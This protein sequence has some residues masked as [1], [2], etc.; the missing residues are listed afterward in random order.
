MTLIELDSLVSLSDIRRGLNM[1]YLEH[2]SRHH[3]RSNHHYD[4]TMIMFDA[5]MADSGFLCWVICNMSTSRN[6]GNE[7]LSYQPPA[8]T[9]VKNKHMVYVLLFRQ[10]SQ[11]ANETIR[12]LSETLEPQRYTSTILQLTSLLKLQDDPQA[13]FRFFALWDQTCDEIHKIRRFIPRKDQMS[14]SQKIELLCETYE[15]LELE[16]SIHPLDSYCEGVIHASCVFSTSPLCFCVANRHSLCLINNDEKIVV[17]DGDII[18]AETLTYVPE[19]SGLDDHTSLETK[20]DGNN[21]K[22][23]MIMMLDVDHTIKDH[24]GLFVQWLVVNVHGTKPSTGDELL[25][26]MFQKNDEIRLKRH[27]L[28]IYRQNHQLN[29]EQID[30]IRLELQQNRQEFQLR[31][32]LKKWPYFKTT[33]PEA[34]NI[35][36]SNNGADSDLESISEKSKTW[37]AKLPVGG[38]EETRGNSLE[39]QP[40]RP[41]SENLTTHNENLTTENKFVKIFLR[42]GAFS[43]PS[44]LPFIIE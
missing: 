31:S 10:M 2:R 3:R 24:D 23:Y 18:P 44:C 22:Y 28:M 8:P 43:P 15:K 36:L 38:Y 34:M 9:F 39:L 30:L 4:Y 21:I 13:I 12:D 20:E 35:Y 14:P 6:M 11:L 42:G 40:R 32:W 5:D 41:P 17:Y 25:P 7:I 16:R 33:Y 37:P 27:A 1:N 29:L 26:Y 19:I